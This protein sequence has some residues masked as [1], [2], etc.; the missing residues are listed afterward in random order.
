MPNRSPLLPFTE[1]GALNTRVCIATDITALQKHGC[2]PV[3]PFGL[4]RTPVIYGSRHWSRFISLSRDRHSQ[5]LA[6]RILDHQRPKSQE[7]KETIKNISRITR[8]VR[9]K[10]KQEGFYGSQ[11]QTRTQKD[12]DSELVVNVAQRARLGVHHVP[13]RNILPKSISRNGGI[14]LQRS[15]SGSDETLR[16]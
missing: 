8:I 2:L 13:D 16:V 12:G 5:P 9:R 11:R 10:K 4:F 3:L 6:G 7:N 15:E 14:K 1:N